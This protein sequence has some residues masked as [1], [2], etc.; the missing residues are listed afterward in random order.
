LTFWDKQKATDRFIEKAKQAIR[1][2]A[3]SRG[4]PLEQLRSEFGWTVERVAHLLRHAY[5]NT[6]SYCFLPYASMPNGLA[7]L[8][9]D[10]IDPRK[11]PYLK[12]NVTTC[13]L[14][15]NTAK[16]DMD[17]EAWERHQLD[18]GAWRRNQERIKSNNQILMQFDLPGF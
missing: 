16:H 14:T 18:W 13:C 10:I 7:A 8:T 11:K 17:P 12:T 9:L 1:G 15:C 3:R 4:I 5:E 2:H 6:C